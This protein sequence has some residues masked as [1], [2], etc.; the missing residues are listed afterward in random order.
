MLPMGVWEKRLILKRVRLL[1]LIPILIAC[2]SGDP[3]GTTTT[4]GPPTSTTNSSTSTIA[5]P[6][7]A[8]DRSTFAPPDPTT[9]SDGASGSGCPEGD[10]PPSDGIWFGHV[11]AYS[12][13][14]V[15]FELAC[16]YIGDIAGEKAAEDNAEAPSDFYIRTT[17]RVAEIPVVED[18]T[19]H[20]IVAPANTAL[21][22]D[23][24][25]YSD[26]PQDPM[27]YTPCPG[28]FCSVWLYVNQGA[29][30]EILEQY[31]P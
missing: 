28:E 5:L 4:S 8:V 14:S 13:V 29:V 1:V 18:A 22:I 27:G 11:T 10:G 31:L 9:S 19:A 12:P 2:G 23:S 17:D 3:G 21:R 6:T 20:T 25:A 16:F 26:W 15:T 7:Y 30:T 24:I